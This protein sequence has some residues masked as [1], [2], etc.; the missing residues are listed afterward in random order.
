MRFVVLC[1]SVALVCLI[2]SGCGGGGGPD[3]TSV[4][5][6]VTLDGSPLQGAKVVFRPTADGGSIS[7]G[8]TDASGAYELAFSYD[9]KGAII[10]DHTVGI[11]KM[12]PSPVDV[13]STVDTEGVLK[14]EDIETLPAKYNSETTLTAKVE[15]GSNNIDFPLESSIDLPLESGE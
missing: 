6:K 12:I 13:P 8:V 9:K 15:S 4:K 14:G 7:S 10:G 2:M 3:L 5:G 11:S 1:C